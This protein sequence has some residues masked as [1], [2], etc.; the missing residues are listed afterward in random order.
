MCEAYWLVHHLASMMCATVAVSVVISLACT[1]G[2]IQLS[3]VHLAVNIQLP[4]G[5]A[6]NFQDLF[7]VPYLSSLETCSPT[8]PL[9]PVP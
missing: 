5:N 8:S 6:D 9:H 7:C 3:V 2:D 4:G 1:N